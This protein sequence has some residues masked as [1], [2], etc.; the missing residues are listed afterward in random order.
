MY[1]F[2]V[3]L[4][5]RHHRSQ[6]DGVRLSTCS[7]VASAGVERVNGPSEEL[8]FPSSCLNPQLFVPPPLSRPRP[9][10]LV[11]LWLW[12]RQTLFQTSV[13]WRDELSFCFCSGVRKHSHWSSFVS[14]L[15]L[16]GKVVVLNFQCSL[17]S[18]K[19]DI[20]LPFCVFRGGTEIKIQLWTPISDKKN[21]WDLV[22]MEKHHKW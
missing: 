10:V 13:S 7:P 20:S 1:L 22:F 4:S 21:E 16:Q 19:C 3:A 8:R 17:S 9:P 18:Y 11:L 14:L 15:W 6:S 5:Q 12:L 2:S